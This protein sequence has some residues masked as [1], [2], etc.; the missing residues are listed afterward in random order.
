[1]GNEQAPPGIAESYSAKM[2]KSQVQLGDPRGNLPTPAPPHPTVALHQNTKTQ[3][4][5]AFSQVNQ[6]KNTTDEATFA[7]WQKKTRLISLRPFET[8]TMRAKR[9]QASSQR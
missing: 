2:P 7:H 5:P 1:M 6:Q 8:Q 4:P 3:F 9:V